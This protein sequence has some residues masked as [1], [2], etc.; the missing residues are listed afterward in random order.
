[1]LEAV[2]YCI[3]QADTQVAQLK[4]QVK[5]KKAELEGQKSDYELR[6]QEQQRR[7]EEV[8]RRAEKEREEVLIASE[9]YKSLGKQ[10]K[11][12]ENQL[13]MLRFKIRTQQME[14]EQMQM[15]L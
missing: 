6:K 9:H 10:W 13:E 3:V 14:L 11:E 4:Q 8:E 7:L 1:M 15:S 2:Q 5:A 12:K